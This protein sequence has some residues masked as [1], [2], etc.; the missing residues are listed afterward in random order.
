MSPP[1]TTRDFIVLSA[2][3][4]PSEAAA[5]SASLEWRALR[6]AWLAALSEAGI[7]EEQARRLASTQRVL[8]VQTLMTVP[9]QKE[10]RA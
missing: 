4:M 8:A 9:A 6:A 3:V 7:S 2:L 1:M 10:A 5:P